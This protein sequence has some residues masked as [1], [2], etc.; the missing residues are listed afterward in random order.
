MRQINVSIYGA[1]GQQ[2]PKDT[3][4]DVNLYSDAVAD[5]RTY[6]SGIVEEPGRL[7]VRMPDCADTGGANLQV[8]AP[9]CSPNFTRGFMDG[10][11]PVPVL[12]S[13]G[14]NPFA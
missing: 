4:V 6:Y 13:E 8:I 12:L 3:P 7:I 10:E 5:Q 11:W 1:D 14:S 9:G 2:L